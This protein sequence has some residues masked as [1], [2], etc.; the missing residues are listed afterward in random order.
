MINKRKRSSLFAA[1]LKLSEKKKVAHC[2]VV[3]T[4]LFYISSMNEKVHSLIAPC[5]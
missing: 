5:L 3:A 1:V 2:F 4:F